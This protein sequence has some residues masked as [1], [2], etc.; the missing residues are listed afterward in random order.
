MIRCG[1]CKRGSVVFLPYR[2]VNLCKRHFLELFERRVKKTIREFHL[3]KKGEHVALGL[4]GGKDSTVLLHMLKRISKVLPIRLTA[5]TVDEGIKGYRRKTITDAQRECKKLGVKH[6]VVSFKDAFGFSLDEVVKKVGKSKSCSYC[7]VLRRYLINR[8]CRRMG[9]DKLAIAHNLDDM[10]QTVLMNIMRNEP[11]RLAR[12]GAK[13]GITDNPY[14][15]PRIKPL[16]RIPEKECA[17]Y[18]LLM[19]MDICYER[20]PYAP[21][22]FR[23]RVRRQLNEMEE[24]YPGTKSRVLNSLLSMQ[25]AL[26]K[27]AEGKKARILR[28]T[29]CGEP[30]STHVCMCCK[31]LGELAA[32]A[33]A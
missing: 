30:S 18:A 7:G 14:F 29:K 10:A 23:E 5:V 22:A 27:E 8:E 6:V 2:N 4:S 20:C 33:Q 11:M 19:G 1:E 26:S 12:F 13:S 24:E 16:I 15:I 17:A 25:K 3:L 32:Q 21:S 31:M 28:C 9:A